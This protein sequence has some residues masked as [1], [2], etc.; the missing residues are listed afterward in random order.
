MKVVGNKDKGYK[1]I[2]SFEETKTEKPKTETPKDKEP[3]GDKK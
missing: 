2:S 3:K 1:V